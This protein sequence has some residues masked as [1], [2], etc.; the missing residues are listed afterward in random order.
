MCK[1]FTLSVIFLILV[2]TV[3]VVSE[4]NS[5]GRINNHVS[6]TVQP[7]LSIP[8]GEN[9]PAE[10]TIINKPP[11]SLAFDEITSAS[12]GLQIGSTTFDNQSNGR[13]NRQVDWRGTNSVHFIW[14]KQTNLYLGG[15]RGT[16][17]EIWNAGAGNLMFPP[18]GCDIHPRLGGGSNYSGYVSLDVDT[19]G[20]AVI[21]NHHDE[22][23]GYDVTVWYDFLPEFCFFSP[24][25]KKIT[26]SVVQYFA[27]G[28]EETIFIWPSHEYQ[29]W[30][31]DTVTH[32]V[33]QQY[34]YPYTEPEV[35]AYFRRI[36]SDTLGYWDYPPQVIDTINYN[37]SH[38]ITASR[39]S[40]KVAITWMAELPEIPGGIESV[41]R[42]RERLNDVYYMLSNDMGETWYTKANVTASDSSRS[43]W[44][45]HCDITSLLDMYD[46]LHI[47]W[48]AREYS[49]YPYPNGSFPHFYGSRLL[50]WSEE[51]SDQIRTI[52]DANWDLPSDGCFGGQWNEMSIVKPQLSECNGKLY[53][54]FVQFNDI[55]GGI[56]ND[57]SE[58]NW[59]LNQ[60]SGTANGEIYLS[61]S[62]NG[63]LSWDTPRNL[64]QSQTPMCDT[65][66]VND[67]DSDM[68]PS[69]SRYGM[70]AS[71]GDYSGA[72]VVD[73][74][75]SYTGDWYMDVIY[76][77]DK[78][79]GSCVSD[80][81][82]FTNNAVKWFRLPCIEPEQAPRITVYPEE[83]G[84]PTHT[85]HGLQLDTALTLE[86]NGNA[87]LV[88]GITVEEITGPEGW[89]N[90]YGFSGTLEPGISG[91]IDGI[92][93]LNDLG[94]VNSPG[95]SV[96][97]I[98]RV[99][100]S[101]NAA[102]LPDTIPVSIIVDDN[103]QYEEEIA[104][105]VYDFSDVQGGNNWYYGYCVDVY[106]YSNFIEM[107]MYGINGWY[108]S[109]GS[110][111]PLIWDDGGIP[112]Q[113]EM[114]VRRW[115]SDYIGEVAIRGE[116]GKDVATEYC[117]DGVDAFIY[118]ND[119]LIWSQS[120]SPDDFRGF[121]YELAAMIQLGDIL[122]FV[123]DMIGDNSC[124]QT[125]FT[126][127]IITNAV[128]DSDN[129][130][131]TNAS[132]NCPYTYNPDQLDDDLDGIGNQCDNC[133]DE[134]NP[135]QEDSDS[136]G[137]GDACDYICGDANSDGSADIKDLVF[138]Y[139]YLYH[140]STAP[141]NPE[142]AD[143][144]GI[145]GVNNHDF[146]YFYDY[147]FKMTVFLQCPPY[148]DTILPVTNDTLLIKY[149]V[150]VPGQS[151][152]RVDLRYI[153]PDPI[154]G[155]SYPFQFDCA[156]SDLL[157]DSV[158]F[159]ESMFDTFYFHEAYIDTALST[160]WIG[161]SFNNY[162]IETDSGLIASLWFSLNPSVDTQFINIDTATFR[163][164]NVVVFSKYTN[165][166]ILTA[167]IPTIYDD[168]SYFVCVDGDG[169]GFGDQGHPEN[170]CPADN[171]PAAFNPDQEDADLDGVGD[172]C[173]SCTDTDGD[174]YGNPEFALNSCDDDNCPLA[175]NPL[176]EDLDL[177]GI[178]DSCDNCLTISNPG[179]EDSDD[180]GTGDACETSSSGWNAM[181]QGIHGS[182]YSLTT[183]NGDVYA[184][185]WFDSAGQVYCSGIAKWNGYEWSSLMAGVSGGVYD[186][187]EY[188]GK[189]V[190][191]GD[192]DSSLFVQSANIA[193]W[194]GSEWSAFPDGADNPV[195]AL[196]VY[197]GNLIAAGDFNLIG[198]IPCQHI[199]AWN[200]TQWSPLG[201]G[202]NG[203]ICD[204]AVY[205]GSLIVGGMFD[206]AGG[207]YCRSVAAWNG[208][209]WSPLGSGIEGHWGTHDSSLAVY[210]GLLIAGGAFDTVGGVACHNIAA[211]D[212]STWAPLGNGI[213]SLP[214]DMVEFNGLLAVAGGS[215]Q[216]GLNHFYGVGF[217]NGFEWGDF[218]TGIEGVALAL[219]VYDSLLIAGGQI[220]LAGGNSVQNVAQWLPF[221][222]DLD[223]DGLLDTA[224]NCQVAYNPTQ[225]DGDNDG[226]GDACDPVTINFTSN[227]QAGSTP[228][229][230]TFTDQSLS[231]GS[232]IERVWD[233]GDSGTD[234]AQISQH[235]YI[236]AGDFDVT[237]IASDGI[238][239]DTL[240]KENYISTSSCWDKISILQSS[241]D[242]SQA[243][244][245]RIS[246]DSLLLVYRHNGSLYS[247]R[248]FD[249]GFTWADADIIS[250]QGNCLVPFLYKAFDGTIWLAW[251]ADPQGYYDL[252]YTRSYDNGRTWEQPYRRI[253]TPENYS[254]SVSIVETEPGT[255]QIYFDNSSRI[256]SINNGNT[257]GAIEYFSSDDI[258]NTRVCR[259][260][261]GRLWLVGWT[262]T[263]IKGRFSD[264]RG[265]SWSDTRLIGAAGGGPD[266]NPIMFEVGGN[267]LWTI[268]HDSNGGNEDLFY[269]KSLD[270]G[271]T[272][273]ERKVIT[274][275]PSRDRIVSASI[276]E[277]N[278]VLR[279]IYSNNR[280]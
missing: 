60:P 194:D 80:M 40:G 178:G 258:F 96:L 170:D 88:Y 153:S 87:E 261:S 270:S 134:Y 222:D 93:Q 159:K 3:S 267:T 253:E 22:G 109:T 100:I 137:T 154:G 259:I 78:M 216:N 81:Q 45:A 129:D 164:S 210:N 98:G 120:I 149:A 82:I 247:F 33:A 56:S 2:M 90:V 54:I 51:Y 91:V 266:D 135:D 19:E 241:S 46:N 21:C 116:V 142:S 133:P 35:I 252:Y 94:I 73:P 218:G 108:D 43:G 169:D 139:Y 122:D 195:S 197:N 70:N 156:T 268:W 224:D 30:G 138:L 242:E 143:V 150:V 117:G 257:F 111:Y 175:F 279:V 26:D 16:G 58:F 221:V 248:S 193:A 272:W 145:T 190:V 152:A 146:V 17:Y 212:G 245:V 92:I 68:W 15:D 48:N 59:S 41:V 236:A 260:S 158:S 207:V 77:N 227:I 126:A 228:L 115:E 110:Q 14:T 9:R 24:Y 168:S 172:S 265:V 234:T 226:Y 36:G 206:T 165:S 280:G 264:D 271:S 6:T 251:C 209:E 121:D 140:D 262:G 49:P 200:G 67:C 11:Q 274:C 99:I 113:N 254:Q 166:D 39:S 132:D 127:S 75:G 176:Q 64:T 250:G 174:G 223:G 155:I 277:I 89:L 231:N 44:R 243:S 114:I 101:G 29:V 128:I 191:G 163:P 66:G 103:F 62:D 255:I 211:W 157:L 151:K 179:Q 86:N 204:L 215:Y 83:I 105:S 61:I 235:T 244:V 196:T 57:C 32:V 230:V 167:I 202:I 205:D 186:M 42:D 28:P 27:D 123:V 10:I 256:T 107:N 25:K 263:Q 181:A 53:V 199:A 74:S 177:D 269:S 187:V 214:F 238:N 240:I 183:Y 171:C 125:K 136:D 208:S 7:A 275:D 184:G 65:T 4:E 198:N 20:K 8:D 173:D 201:S 237:L 217:W 188:G 79:A 1:R 141:P 148:P 47:I 118:L 52:K 239:A 12:P 144:D 225:T 220:Y 97:L 95:T 233:F 37:F 180:D 229:L 273:S 50:H 249:G 192:F 69:I 112:G 161:V 147:L 18:Q 119:S 276:F 278:G 5:T 31:G 246:N 102:G 124:D 232:I 182:I 104:N 63:G 130:G 23:D 55:F 71:G 84:Y 38:S 76:I 131:I 34:N 203:M 85:P 160:A 106:D 219:T 72:V 162:G 13:M 213:N 189:L 185:G